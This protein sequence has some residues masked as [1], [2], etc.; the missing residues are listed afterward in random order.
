MKPPCHF[1][2]APHHGHDTYGVPFYFSWLRSVLPIH[3]CSLTLVCFNTPFSIQFKMSNIRKETSCHSIERLC[4]IHAV[5]LNMPVL[6]RYI[7]VLKAKGLLAKC[8][9]LMKTF[10]EKI[11]TFFILCTFYF[12]CDEIILNYV[13]SAEITWRK[14]EVVWQIDRKSIL[15]WITPGCRLWSNND[16]IYF[17]ILAF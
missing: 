9:F 13:I 16:V 17:Q 12:V 5:L 10:L 11:I 1:R 3:S 2:F 6:Q 15:G 8:P 4:S 7:F 14:W